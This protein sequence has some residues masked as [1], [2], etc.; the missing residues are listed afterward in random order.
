MDY[1]TNDEE[2]NASPEGSL[3][4]DVNSEEFAEQ[5]VEMEEDELNDLKENPKKPLSDV[6]PEDFSFK[7]S[8][9]DEEEPEYSTAS[10]LQQSN[11]GYR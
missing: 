6:L 4:G 5:Y 3:F 2:E 10:E 9:E 8:K 1:D 7:T 11:R